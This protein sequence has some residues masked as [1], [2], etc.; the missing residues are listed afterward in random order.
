MWFRRGA[1]VEQAQELGFTHAAGRLW[2][3]RQTF[4]DGEGDGS[5]GFWLWLISMRPIATRQSVSM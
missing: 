5:W 1:V 3:V 4:D 2:L